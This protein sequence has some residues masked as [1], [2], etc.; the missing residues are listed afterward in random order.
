MTPLKPSLH[1]Y[2]VSWS[3]FDN[4]AENKLKELVTSWTYQPYLTFVFVF[5]CGSRHL[6]HLDPE[7]CRA[8]LNGHHNPKCSELR[9]VSLPTFLSLLL[10]KLALWFLFSHKSGRR[11]QWRWGHWVWGQPGVLI[12]SVCLKTGSHWQRETSVL[13]VQVLPGRPLWPSCC[14]H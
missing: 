11:R 8:Q 6:T 3:Y 5:P 13:L 12:W 7:C 10:Y 4:E 9:R 14:A 1:F 2:S